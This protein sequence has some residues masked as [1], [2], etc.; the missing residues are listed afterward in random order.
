MLMSVLWVIGK[1][2]GG[3][4]EGFSAEIESRIEV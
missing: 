4:L 2:L 3:Q 1:I